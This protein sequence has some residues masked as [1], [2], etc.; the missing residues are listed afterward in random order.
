MIQIKPFLQLKLVLAW[1]NEVRTTSVPK[2]ATLFRADVGFALD[3]SRAPNP[4]D[5]KSAGPLWPR[6]VMPTSKL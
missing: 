2:N 4:C 1:T 5:P 3:P 6:Y